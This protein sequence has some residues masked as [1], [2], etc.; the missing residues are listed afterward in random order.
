MKEKAVRENVKRRGGTDKDRQSQGKGENLIYELIYRKYQIGREKAEN[1]FT[2]LTELE[3]IVLYTTLQGAEKT[4]LAELSEKLELPLY[5]VSDIAQKLQA[6]GMVVWSHDGDGSKGTYLMVTE[7]GKE[8][9][10]EQEKVLAGYYEKVI[11][12]FG[13][14]RLAGLLEELKAL[15]K[16]TSGTVGEDRRNDRN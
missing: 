5:L 4:Y 1:I 12:A 16:I 14:E 10:S 8:A 13:R 2:R 9:L 6:N 3:Y 11:A 15:A 7:L